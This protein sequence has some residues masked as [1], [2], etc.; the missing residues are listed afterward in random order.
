[1]LILFMSYVPASPIAEQ[2][3][4]LHSYKKLLQVLRTGDG[5]EGQGG[6]TSRER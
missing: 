1:V 2:S 6:R 3:S 5:E 4:E